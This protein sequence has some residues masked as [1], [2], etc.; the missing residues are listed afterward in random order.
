MVSFRWLSRCQ[1]LTV[2]MILHFLPSAF[3]LV[4]VTEEDFD[5]WTS[6]VHPV[7]SQKHVVVGL[8]LLIIFFLK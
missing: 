2:I 6:S 3:V 5:M 1:Y 7:I 8:I 4:I